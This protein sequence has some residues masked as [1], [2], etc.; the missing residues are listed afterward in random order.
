MTLPLSGVVRAPLTPAG[1]GVV[2][3]VIEN[4][5][6]VTLRAGQAVMP[7]SSGSGVERWNGTRPLIGLVAVDLAPMMA[8]AV[9]LSGALTFPDWG[10][11]TGSAALV[12]GSR[13]FADDAVPGLLTPV[14]PTQS[15]RVLQLVGI[16]ISTVTLELRFT[17]QILL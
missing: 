13:Y 11:A 4:R 10:L 15:G 6:S 7:H 5:D 3:Y 9:V 1:A 17:D 14:A 2:S 12:P 16:A 8:G